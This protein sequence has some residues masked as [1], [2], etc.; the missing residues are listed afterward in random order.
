LLG[1]EWAGQTPK[2]T[3]SVQELASGVHL[4]SGRFDGERGP[5][6]DTIFF[7]AAQGL[8]LV[9]TG[10]HVWH[11][12]AIV[13]YARQRERPIAAIINTHWRLDHSSGKLCSTS[14]RTISGARRKWPVT[15]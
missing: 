5:D 11:G 6:G 14:T 4:L 2:P 12:D 7:D 13:A 15:T 3:P 9:D 8:V 1:A 10:R